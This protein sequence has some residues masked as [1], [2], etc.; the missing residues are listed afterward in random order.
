MNRVKSVGIARAMLCLAAVA[1]LAVPRGIAQEP[2]LKQ[3]EQRRPLDVS[4]APPRGYQKSLEGILAVR[5]GEVLSDPQWARAAEWANEWLGKKLKKTAGFRLPIK[6]QDI[7]QIT[8]RLLLSFEKRSLMLGFF[9]SSIRMHEPTNWTE[10]IQA[11]PEAKVM[12]LDGMTTFSYQFQLL[13]L[14]PEEWL[15]TVRD[16]W[17]DKLEG[18]RFTIVGTVI[19]DRTVVFVDAAERARDKTEAPPEWAPEWQE[20]SAGLLALVLHNPMQPEADRPAET[21][22]TQAKEE[23]RDSVEPVLQS[24]TRF[25]RLV[26]GV[27][28]RERIRVKAWV[29]CRTSGEARAV[30][31]AMTKASGDLVKEKDRPDANRG[32]VLWANLAASAAIKQVGD[33]V[34]IS[35]ETPKP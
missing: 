28:I 12:T 18:Q 19:D 9:P 27:D 23:P 5:V 35:A 29:I 4:L 32:D 33:K 15:K 11:I 2:T 1:M 20:I 6:V 26:V 25:S 21:P 14:L 17:G 13:K 24:L 22:P 10:I 16:L 8:V 30:A 31:R 3:A 34:T 7:D